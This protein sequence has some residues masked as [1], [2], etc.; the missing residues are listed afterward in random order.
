MGLWP[1]QS[2]MTKF[3]H[4]LLGLV[5]LTIPPFPPCPASSIPLHAPSLELDSRYFS[6][7]FSVECRIECH[8][9]Y[10]VR[11]ME[12]S[13][14]IE[15]L[16]DGPSGRTRASSSQESSASPPKSRRRTTI[17]PHHRSGPAAATPLERLAPLIPGTCG[18]VNLPPQIT[19]LRAPHP[20]TE[21]T[22]VFVSAGALASPRACGCCA[23]DR[24]PGAR[25][26]LRQSRQ[27]RVGSE[28]PSPGHYDSHWCALGWGGRRIRHM[29]AH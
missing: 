25:C 15:Q 10:S 27:E 7:V 16:S 9:I 4:R 18:C 13:A 2:A 8:S 21:S 26:G 28:V 11:S 29:G 19:R 12:R 3:D 14:A 5:L 24:R 6:T 23:P 17:P 22:C 20:S 1:K